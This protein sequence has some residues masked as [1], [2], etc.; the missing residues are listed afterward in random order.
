MTVEQVD[1]LGTFRIRGIAKVLGEEL[2]MSESEALLLTLESWTIATSSRCSSLEIQLMDIITAKKI[3]GSKLRQIC[4][5]IGRRKR[6]SAATL[7]L[8]I[9]A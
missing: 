8:L 3:R 2:A 9:Q 4:F 5:K 1:G 6:R 7:R